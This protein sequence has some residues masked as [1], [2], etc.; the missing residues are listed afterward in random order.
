[1]KG[2]LISSTEPYSGKSAIVVGLTLA[3]RKRGYDVGFM[4]PVGNLITDVDGV[5]CDEDTLKIIDALRI[6]EPHEHVCP[7]L[8][9]D[10]LL[11]DVLSGQSKRIKEKIRE[12]YDR[13][14]KGRDVMLVEGL[15]DFGGGAMMGLSD[16]DMAKLLDLRILLIV[17]YGSV[18]AVDSLLKDISF[19]KDRRTLV[20]VILNDVKPA[21][22]NEVKTKVKPFLERRGLRVLGILPRDDILRS[23]KVSDIVEQLHG[24]V[25]AG[26]DYLDNLVRNIVVGAME[27]HNAL[28]FFRRVDDKIVVSG[29]DRSVVLTAALETST[30][31]LLLTG[32]LKPTAQLLARAEERHVPVILV[33]DDTAST[34]YRLGEMHSR[35]RV[36][37]S[38]KVSR[39]KSMVE[40]NV[41]LKAILR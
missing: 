4:K 33:P 25:L 27:P 19:I 31:C 2:I 24:K 14:K 30:K 16:I 18:Y 40:K 35:I 36:S 15:G 7:I 13:L 10:S 8:L 32:N 34:V 28:R 20:G 23:I 12:A 1:M 39:M 21:R 6:R 41:D 26:E 38:R 11:V 29:G 22:M 5:L 37:G 9:T 17:K 3:L